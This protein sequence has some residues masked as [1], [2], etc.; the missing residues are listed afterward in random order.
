MSAATPALR[1]LQ[2]RVRQGWRASPL[3]GFFAWWGGELGALLPPR[4]RAALAGGADWHLL[5][6]VDGDWR[7]A[8]QRESRVQAVPEITQTPRHADSRRLAA[9]QQAPTYGRP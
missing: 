7:L 5:Q 3:P 1:S 9:Q 4:W 8:G 2:D 6:Q